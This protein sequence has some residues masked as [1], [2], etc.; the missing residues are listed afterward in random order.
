MQ[1]SMIKSNIKIVVGVIAGMALAVGE[2]NLSAGCQKC[3]TGSASPPL[4]VNPAACDEGTAVSVSCDGTVYSCESTTDTVRCTVSEEK[5]FVT[6]SFYDDERRLLCTS[7]N[8]YHLCA[9]DDGCLYP[10]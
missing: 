1:T 2:A 5:V 6:C 9:T 7:G 10:N 8:Y 3:K 4:I